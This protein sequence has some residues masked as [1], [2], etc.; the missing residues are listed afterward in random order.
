MMDLYT[1]NVVIF[2]DTLICIVYYS[3]DCLYHSLWLRSKF[4]LKESQGR[5]KHQNFTYNIMAADGLA[6]T[7]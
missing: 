5:Q 1:F 7:R 3:F 4:S 6:T 2:L